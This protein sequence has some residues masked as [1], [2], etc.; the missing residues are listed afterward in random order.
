MEITLAQEL[1]LSKISNIVKIVIIV[2]LFVIAYYS[3]FVD[4]NGKYS[5]TD[6]YYSHGYLIPFVSAFIIWHK[7]DKLKN[8]IVVPCQAGLWML[9]GG[10]L[11]YLFASWWFVNFVA[12]SSMIIVLWGL[13]LY[14][15][16]KKITR[17]LVF[18]L[19]FLSF[20]IPLPQIAIIHITFWLKLFAAAMATELVNLMGIVAVVKGAFIALPN[21]TLEVDNACSGLRSLIALLALGTAYAYFLRVSLPKKYV[22]FLASIPIATIANLL[23]IIILILISYVYG[24]TGNAFKRTDTTTGFLVFVFALIGL[25]IVGKWVTLWEKHKR[26]ISSS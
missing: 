2:F 4:L 24:P 3:V 11:L 1:K 7:R 15:F 20:M 12:A 6:S 19:A 18:P 21:T 8:M 17:E 16:G 9:G 13:S 23:R 26:A 22:F 10:L 5:R 14:L 25:N